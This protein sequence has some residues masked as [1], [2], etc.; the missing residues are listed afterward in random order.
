[1][2]KINCEACTN[3]RCKEIAARGGYDHWSC[4]QYFILNDYKP[5]W[6]ECE[7]M[8]SAQRF[9]S[10]SETYWR[11]FAWFRSVM[12]KQE[13]IWNYPEFQEGYKFGSNPRE[14][15]R[16]ANPYEEPSRNRSWDCGY[17]IGLSKQAE[18]ERN[19]LKARK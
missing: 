18:Q 10:D 14:P 4:L 2:K 9:L 16:D 19:N 6:L 13:Y 12:M 1:M 11:N 15:F 17:M 8:T 3:Y 5:R 7:L